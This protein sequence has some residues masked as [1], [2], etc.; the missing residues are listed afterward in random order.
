MLDDINR[1]IG[2]G[3]LSHIEEDIGKNVADDG[4]QDYGSDEL[5]EDGRIYPLFNPDT[6]FSRRINL[7]AHLVFPNVEILRAAMQQ[8]IVD[9]KYNFFSL[10]N[11]SKR[12][13]AIC[14]DRCDKCLLHKKRVVRSECTCDKQ[15]CNFYIHASK[16][17]EEGTMQTKTYR[18][19]H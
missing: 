19:E 12:F 17:R 9:N 7:K 6:N 11:N 1:A 8:H 15:N 16:L 10:H 2:G 4:E 18:L 5:E 13:D 3:W 14:V